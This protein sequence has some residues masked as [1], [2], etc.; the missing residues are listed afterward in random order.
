[1]ALQTRLSTCTTFEDMN[2]SEFITEILPRLY[3]PLYQRAM[4]W[5]LTSDPRNK[6]IPNCRDYIKYIFKHSAVVQRIHVAA[7]GCKRSLIDGNN[8]I[9]AILLFIKLPYKLFPVYYD[10]LFSLIDKLFPPTGADDDDNKY[11][12][13]LKDF[14]ENA[15]YSTIVEWSDLKSGF[16]SHPD[17]YEDI[18]KPHVNKDMIYEFSEC[19]CRIRMKWGKNKTKKGKCINLLEDVKISFAIYH[20]YTVDE[21]VNTFEETNRYESSMSKRDAISASLCYVNADM[22]EQFKKSL[23]VFIEKYLQNKP[24]DI[25]KLIGI[26]KEERVIKDIMAFDFLVGLN[27]LCSE[28]FKLFN[29]YNE[30]CSNKNGGGNNK[31][32]MPIIFD[33]F[34]YLY[35]PH[36][37]ENTNSE[38]Y[39]SLFTFDNNND[40]N[41]KFV[42][43]CDVISSA[44][45]EMYPIK[46]EKERFVKNNDLSF[47]KKI[48]KTRLLVLLTM[49]I[50]E[51]K[52]GTINEDIKSSLKIVL[53]FHYFVKEL[54]AKCKNEDIIH[55]FENKDILRDKEIKGNI[56]TLLPKVNKKCI[57]DR[58]KEITREL[59]Y[60]LLCILNKFSI[61]PCLNSSKKSRRSLRYYDIMMMISAYYRKMPLEYI[62]NHDF[63]TEHIYPHS[64]S[65]DSQLEVDID[66]LGNRIPILKNINNDRKNKH[67]NCYYN[68]HYNFIK[69]LQPFICTEEEYDRTVEYVKINRFTKPKFKDNDA[70]DFYKQQCYQNEYNYINNFLDGLY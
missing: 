57:I 40:F 36:F 1:M 37:T 47:G 60:G 62:N 21:Q 24:S 29:N 17:I 44:L 54:K 61:K 28:R 4:Y 14:F 42:E 53:L 25:E 5:L 7:T 45:K 69:H 20:N 51:Q 23:Y 32:V 50:K 18:I 30:F 31:N 9:N 11:N 12:K 67:I 49:I 8:R 22:D 15:H 34:N 33:L 55:K 39:S 6:K 35:N 13:K 58:S 2:L 68:N 43:A 66:R 19:I 59:F 64:T 52:H 27:D 3:K 46:Y 38:I 63:Q 16:A 65:W 56:K 48:D 26:D 10:E 70:I 41:N